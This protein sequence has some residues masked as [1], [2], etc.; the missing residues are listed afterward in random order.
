MFSK[1]G[2]S[3]YTHTT[4][5][6]L[7][8]VTAHIQG[9]FTSKTGDV[10]FFYHVPR[11]YIKPT[12]NVT[13]LVFSITPTS[14][15]YAELESSPG[16]AV[17]FLHRPFT[18]N[19]YSVPRGTTVLAC[20]KSFDEVLTVGYN[21]A[22]ANRLGMNVQASVCLQGYK[23]D[24]ARRI[25]IIGNFL[26]PHQ[27]A[28]QIMKVIRSEFG[29]LEG[30]FG[31]DS[32]SPISALAI[33]NAFHPGEVNRV[34]EDAVAAN[35]V[36]S[37]AESSKILYLTGAVREEGLKAARENGMT[38]V[39]VGHKTCEEWGVRFLAAEARASFPGLQVHEVYE[40]EDCHQGARSDK[41]RRE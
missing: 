37:P 18:L 34:I 33:M 12:T 17:G 23:G 10:S 24:P 15:F 4:G 13:R 27:A 38:V 28:K 6:S 19:R 36:A 8:A 31:M 20:H 39:C 7:Q 22:L 30:E 35:I 1:N 41:Q 26:Q 9:F 14:G 5:F 29:T 21:V 32:D 25:G 40:D 11:P 16:P 3:Q 2:A